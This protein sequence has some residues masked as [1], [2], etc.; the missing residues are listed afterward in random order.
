MSHISTA[1]F[2]QGNAHVQLLYMQYNVVIHAA[3]VSI[4]LH[5]T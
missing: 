4:S 5:E 2:G 1:V 3:G